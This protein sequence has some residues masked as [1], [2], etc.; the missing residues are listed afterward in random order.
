M[1]T[2]SRSQSSS[3]TTAESSTSSILSSKTI[4]DILVKSMENINDED[5]TEEEK[6]KDAI[7]EA[8]NAS[9]LLKDKTKDK[10]DKDL[11]NLLKDKQNSDKELADLLKSKK[12]DDKELSGLLK[13]NNKEKSSTSKV[14]GLGAIGAT[15]G[16]ILKS[17]SVGQAAG[18]VVSGAGKAAG[19]LVS[20]VGSLGGSA[21][22]GIGKLFGPVGGV[23]GKAVGAAVAAPFNAVGGLITKTLTGIGNLLSLPL[24]E[25][26]TKA[27]LIL[28]VGSQIFVFLEGLIAKFK[29]DSDLRAIDFGAKI[30]SYISVIP[31]KIKLSLE[32]ILSKVRIAGKPIYGS[33]SS[34]EE[35]EL[36]N[37]AIR[38]KLAG[39]EL[40]KNDP[41]YQYDQLLN[42]KKTGIV[43]KEAELQGIQD[44]MKDQF[45]RYTGGGNL[46]LSQYNLNTTAGKE[47]L[48]ADW[49]SNVSEDDKAIV[50]ENIDSLLADYSYTSGTLSDAK[51]RAAYLEK[52]N[53]E[54]ARYKELSEMADKPRDDAYFEEE[55]AKIDA[56]FD[57]KYEDYVQQGLKKEVEKGDLTAYEAER[58]KSKFGWGTQVD[59]VLS[60]YKTEHGTDYNFA[61]ATAAEK[62]L[63][64]QYKAW[65]NTWKDVVSHTLQNTIGVN[66]NVNQETSRTNPT[67]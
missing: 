46:D 53:P 44:E 60:D 45:R 23:I 33:L 48:K 39:G 5:K 37:L 43:A 41:L 17:K 22:A 29:A 12:N 49:L 16:A 62:F 7:T 47:A 21:I 14:L 59:A 67:M 55:Q 57:E 10:N 50:A 1:A 26:V 58:A 24:K 56:K 61:P 54:I 35:E 34:A 4:A 31:D 25:M 20:G 3:T 19:G 18:T 8:I 40:G 65:A 38:A 28:A 6:L 9:D 51:K 11:N 13:N 30:K 27:G 52:T 32:K 63:E 66:V 64:N 2:Y 42:N 15:L 36:G